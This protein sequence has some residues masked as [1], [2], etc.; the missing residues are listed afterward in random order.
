MVLLVTVPWV[1]W[2]GCRKGTTWAERQVDHSLVDI[3]A[4][5][6]NLRHDLVGHDQ[7]QARATFV[8]VDAHNAHD[9]DLM[10]TLGGD[11][12]AAGGRTVGDTRPAS[13]RIPAGGVRTFALVDRDEAHRPEA[14]SAR[15][16]ILGAHAPDYVAPVQVTDGKVYRDGDRVVVNAM[17]RNAV[18]RPVRVIVLAGFYDREG[19]PMT[20]PFTEMYIPGDSAHPAQFVGPVG[21]EKGYIFIGDMVF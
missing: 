15:V 4:E 13:L 11:L 20:R 7:W 6:L 5:H 14:T 21:S 16:Q 10:V 18:D 12:V 17:I 9:R 8:L 3:D 2:A 1:S 19:T